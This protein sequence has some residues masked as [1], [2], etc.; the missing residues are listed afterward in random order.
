MAITKLVK[1]AAIAGSEPKPKIKEVKRP[2]PRTPEVP[3]VKD[4]WTRLEKFTKKNRE[5]KM[6]ANR[7]KNASDVDFQIQ[8][9]VSDPYTSGATAIPTRQKKT[10]LKRIKYQNCRKALLCHRKTKSEY[11]DSK[12]NRKLGRVGKPIYRMVLTKVDP[13][14]QRNKIYNYERR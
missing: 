8:R 13:N 9:T 6:E 4:L 10:N 11:K 12:Q 1:R 14:T 3:K 2:F 5:S 7:N